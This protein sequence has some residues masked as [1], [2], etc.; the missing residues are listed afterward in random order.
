[1]LCAHPVMD[2]NQ[3]RLEI[4]EDE[5]DDRQELLGHVGIPTFGNGVMIVAVLAQASVAAPIVRDDQRPGSNGAI[6]KSAKRFGASVSGDR[7]PNAPRIAPIVSLV[8]RGSRLAMAHLYGAGDQN[9]VVPPRPSPR[10]RPPI[11]V[12]STSTCSF[13]RPP[14]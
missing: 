2:A 10:V 14:M 5:M 9:L 12:S 4:R 6:D 1:M 11:Q 13:A 7:Q 8:L 3:P